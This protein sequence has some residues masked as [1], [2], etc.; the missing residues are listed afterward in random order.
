[1]SSRTR[2]SRPGLHSRPVE[3]LHRV[4]VLLCRSR[5]P[6]RAPHWLEPP[7][8]GRAVWSRACRF[9]GLRHPWGCGR[10]PWGLWSPR[11]SGAWCGHVQRAWP[12]PLS[13]GS[14]HFAAGSE[15]TCHGGGG[16]VY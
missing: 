16:G 8:M 3:V 10:W 5:D 6:S 11:R 1:M 4:V 13:R 14:L 15:A 9:L 12:P 7:T 2:L